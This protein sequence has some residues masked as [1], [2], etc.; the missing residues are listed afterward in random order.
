MNI[1]DNFKSLPTGNNVTDR[2][3]TDNDRWT[4]DSI[5]RTLLT[6]KINNIYIFINFT[7]EMVVVKT[8]TT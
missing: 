4:A 7:K 3:Q 1:A 5:S 6:G 8:H 2:R